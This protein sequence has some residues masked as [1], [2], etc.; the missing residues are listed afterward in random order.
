MVPCYWCYWC[1]HN[2][3][4]PAFLRGR[5]H[6]LLDKA[7]N[8]PHDGDG[9]DGGSAGGRPGLG[10]GPRRRSLPGGEDFVCAAEDPVL[11]SPSPGNRNNFCREKKLVELGAQGIVGPPVCPER[12]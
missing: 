8:V 6:L 9:G 5:G 11:P 12:R 7:S 1:Q 4:R 2:L 10:P 3:K